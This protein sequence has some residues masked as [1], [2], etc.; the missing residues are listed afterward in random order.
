[1][2]EFL[3]SLHDSGSDGAPNAR[4]HRIPQHQA[5]FISYGESEH[6]AD[7]CAQRIA[8]RLSYPRS[9]RIAIPYT[10]TRSHDI[11]TLVG[12]DRVPHALV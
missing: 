7:L 11:S 1:V 6:A 12:P 3:W 2:P 5:Q 4:P 9:E 10:D 8:Q